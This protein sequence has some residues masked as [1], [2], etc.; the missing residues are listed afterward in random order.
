MSVTEV[1]LASEVRAQSREA[2]LRLLDVSNERRRSHNFAWDSIEDQPFCGWGPL[3][4]ARP[5]RLQTPVTPQRPAEPTIT[6]VEEAKP[7]PSQAAV[8]MLARSGAGPAAPG[9]PVFKR[10][11]VPVTERPTL[12]ENLDSARA[13]CKTVLHNRTVTKDTTPRLVRTDSQVSTSPRPGRTDSQAAPTLFPQILRRHF[14]EVRVRPA[15]LKQAQFNIGAVGLQQ[16]PMHMQTTPPPAEP[17]KPIMANIYTTGAPRGALTTHEPQMR[18]RNAMLY[19][20]PVPQM[21]RLEPLGT[22]QPRPNRITELG[23]APNKGSSTLTRGMVSAQMGG[24]PRAPYSSQGMSLR[25]NASQL[26]AQKV[27]ARYNQWRFVQW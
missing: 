15:Q 16:A 5:P 19:P 2:V 10:K 17:E 1:R 3:P 12:Y 26:A 4:T 21:Q 6:R 23:K 20:P 8:S 27:D 14:E 24:A 7:V 9:E 13:G 25:E 11:R 18:I 22:I